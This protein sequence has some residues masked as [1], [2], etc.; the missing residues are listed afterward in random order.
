MTLHA[1][2]PRL[3]AYALG[4][5]TDEERAEFERE[6]AA[7][8]EAER[9]LAEIRETI[10]LVRRELAAEPVPVIAAAASKTIAGDAIV[11]DD[12]PRITQAELP[13]R[14]S[15]AFAYVAAAVLLAATGIAL[16]LPAVYSMRELNLHTDAIAIAPNEKGPVSPS[17]L[18]PPQQQSHDERNFTDSPTS[19]PGRLREGKPTVASESVP[20]L[21]QPVK[22]LR[23]GDLTTQPPSSS[24]SLEIEG[25]QDT[26]GNEALL[27]RQVERGQPVR[28]RGVSVGFPYQRLQDESNLGESG[29]FSQDP[30]L[31]HS[32]TESVPMLSGTGSILETEPQG[33]LGAVSNLNGSLDQTSDKGIAYTIAKPVY[34]TKT[35][36]K[37]NH[38]DDRFNGPISNLNGTMDSAAGEFTLVGPTDN[39]GAIAT[40]E[41]QLRRMAREQ[42]HNTEAYAAIVENPFLA[43]MQN[44]LSTFSIDVDTA[45]YS[46]VR[47]FL[48]SGTL[49]PPGAVRIEEL[50]N[51]FRYDYGAPA[52]TDGAPF[53]AH[54]EVAECPWRPEHR[55]VRIGLKGREIAA[56][57]RPASN[58]VFLLDVSGSMNQPNK[59][60]LVKQGLR[61][62]VEGLREND[63]V[64]IVVYAGASGLVLE[65]TSGDNQETIL[66]AIDQLT[67]GG[68]T[69]GASGIQLAYEVAT[70]HFIKGGTNRVILAT[71]GDFNVG[72]TDQSQLVKLI[73]EQAKSDVFLSVLGFGM[74]N[75]KDST[76]E[77]LADRGNG[78]Y[79]Y[80][81]TER[82][83]RK[84]LVEQL[85]GTLITIAK[86]VKIQLEFNPARVAAYRL[87]GYENRL[88]AKEDFNDD[89]KDA[90]E[91]GAGHTVTAL[92]EVVP[93]ATQTDEGDGEVDEAAKAQGEEQE[94]T[95]DREVDELEYLT[96]SRPSGAAL[97]SPNLLTLKLRYKEPEG[98]ESKLLKFAVEDAER[99]IGEA[100]TDFQ[101]AASVAA[102]GMLLRGSQFSGTA[103]YDAIMEWAQPTLS[104]DS[105]GY[106]RELI[107]LMRT[108]RELSKSQHSQP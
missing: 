81:D 76:L 19:S 30:G 31:N 60:P 75:L 54:M 13:K 3:T 70:R 29:Y 6:L 104:S 28:G 90:G 51:Y 26:D 49:P 97:A 67:P 18:E 84:V 96:A 92:Y 56:E 78:N 17:S 106:R 105:E 10:A 11:V 101:L 1:D 47:R 34:E 36:T 93:V 48:T 95:V 59:L 15:R 40:D 37:Q 108:A 99:R 85:A 38:P 45:S 57:D 88:L 64:A 12:A 20:V 62:L 94:V 4:E 50:V 79:A 69:N 102:F 100:S 73:E 61:M 7:S 32:L 103:N 63:R 35:K 65:S 43:V 2:D 33:A 27:L 39:L 98:S 46:N 16:T 14:R 52:D 21:G 77:Q 82:E 58:L 80:V 74:G 5:L 71:D 55:L 87:I 23:M 83:A 24:S 53:A 68:S 72:V 9:E 25:Y 107:D 42:Y 89:T 22:K 86:D 91:I 44:P 66:S 8:P 41:A